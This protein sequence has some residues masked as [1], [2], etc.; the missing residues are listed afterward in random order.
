MFASGG[1]AEHI[2][3]VTYPFG[4]SPLMPATESMEK[5]TDRF[6]EMEILTQSEY[7][8]Y[9]YAN[10]GDFE[11]FGMTADSVTIY[12]NAQTDALSSVWFKLSGQSPD[13]IPAVYEKAVDMYGDTIRYWQDVP[14]YDFNGEIIA[15]SPDYLIQQAVSAIGTENTYSFSVIWITKQADYIPCFLLRVSCGGQHGIEADLIWTT[16]PPE[17]Y[18]EYMQR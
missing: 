3:G 15:H 1:H 2:P 8:T 12:V 5:L 4:V 16:I 11:I 18:E 7:G 14:D 9:Y 13:D 17:E 6:G 10:L